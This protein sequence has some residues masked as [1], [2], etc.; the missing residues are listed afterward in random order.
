MARGKPVFVAL[1]WNGT[2]VP[3]F[4]LAPYSGV[5]EIIADWRARGL[6]VFVVS[7]AEQKTIERDVER[8]G[9][10]NDGVFGCADKGPILQDLC[11]RYGD[12]MLLGDHPTDLWAACTAGI[13]FLQAGLEGQS[14]L[15]EADGYYHEWGEVQLLV[16][17]LWGSVP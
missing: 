5:L 8:A 1:D 4:G 9:L 3:F 7:R 14:R 11:A 13:P 17:A 6:L 16:E 15:S 12:G 2:V 10:L